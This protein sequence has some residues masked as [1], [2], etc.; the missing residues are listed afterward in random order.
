MLVGLFVLDSAWIVFFGAVAMFL[1]LVEWFQMRTADTLDDSF[2]G[3]DFSQGYTS[4][5]RSNKPN[6]P[7]A[8][9]VRDGSRPG[10]SAAASP[11]NSGPASTR[12]RRSSSSTRSW[13]KFTSN[14]ISSLTD[15]ERRQ[16]IRASARLARPGQ[17]PEQ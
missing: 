3:Y 14:G 13:P 11:R 17:A 10:A 6:Q 1:S 8:A 12:N 2:M 7:A 5:E 15:A 9:A 4:L 16:L